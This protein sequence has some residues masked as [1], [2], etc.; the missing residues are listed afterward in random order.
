PTRRSSDLAGA[1]TNRF[2]PLEN[3]DGRRVVLVLLWCH[4]PG[5]SLIDRRRG[6]ACTPERT[7]PPPLA[8]SLHP[9]LRL[10]AHAARTRPASAQIDE[11]EHER[12]TPYPS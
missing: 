4:R 9:T 7:R 8:P 12:D 6:R 2:E 5:I 3:S 1:L 10:D 11:F